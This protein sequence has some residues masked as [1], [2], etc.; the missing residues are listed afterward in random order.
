M[1]ISNKIECIITL[2]PFI[3]LIR[4]G[5]QLQDQEKLSSCV[6]IHVRHDYVRREETIMHM[7]V[8]NLDISED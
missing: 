4:R 2:T 6:D 3:K 5:L 8:V 7:E 1:L